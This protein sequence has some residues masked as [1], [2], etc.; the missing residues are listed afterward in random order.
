[1]VDLWALLTQCAQAFSTGDQ[2]IAMET[3]SQIRQ[4]SSPYGDG[5]ERLA[6]YFAKGL[7]ARLT[8]SIDSCIR[9]NGI[10]A[11]E[12][13]RSYKVYVTACPFRRITNGFA[14][15]NIVKLAEQATSLHII[16]FGISYGFQWPCLIHRLSK[17]LGG[18]PRL[19]ITGIDLPQPGFRPAERIEATMRRLNGCCETVNVPFEYNAIAKRWETIQFEDLDL[20]DDELVV[21]NCMYRLRNLP[22]DSVVLS[23]PRDTVLKLIRRINPKM[24]IHGVVNGTYNVPFFATR[25]KE[26]LFHFS[27][28]FDILEETLPREDEQRLLLER[29]MFG[30]DA[31]NVVA[32]EGMER[33]DRP[34]TYKQWQKRNQKAGFVQSR[35][36]R[37]I[38]DRVMKVVR[39]DYN[40]KFFVDVD[41]NWMLQGW[42]G[43][44]IHA[45]SCWK[46]AAF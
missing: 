13:L 7:E 11:A 36:D 41:G 31:M 45:I 27:T 3:L 39:S 1:M 20:R 37:S 16:D 28:L 38:M 6:H 19:R 22:D 17:R 30:R 32:C 44:V 2:E 42:K 10:S 12:I 40:D 46:P 43:R 5:N 15:R 26:A 9:S 33:F 34:E 24:F 4:H 14:N 25:F 21:V 23:S 8:G 29:E 35:L 18:P